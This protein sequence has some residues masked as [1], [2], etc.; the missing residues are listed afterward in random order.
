MQKA[1]TLRT[2]ESLKPQTKRYDVRD[3]HLPGFGV[4]VGT[5]GQITFMIAYRYG[6]KQRRVRLGRYP[7]LGLAE[8]RERAMEMLRKVDEGGDP[9]VSRRS[10]SHRVEHVVDEFITK[11]AKPKNRTWADTQALLRR[12]FVSRHGH[13]DIR[14]ITR[15]EIL[16]ILDANVERGAPY[17]ANR[18]RSQLMKLFNWCIERSYVDRNPVQ[19]IKPLTKERKRDRI[20]TNDEIKRLV[21]LCRKEGYP[22]GDLYLMLLVTGQRRGEATGMRWSEIDRDARVW[23]MPSER[24]KNDHPHSVPLSDMAL[25]ILDRVPRYIGSDF[26][27]TTTGRSAVSGWGKPKDRLTQEAEVS[28][29]R[30][31]DLRRTASSGM[32]SLGVA[33]H[34]IEKILNHVSG[35]ISGVAAVYNRYGYEMEK[36]DALDRWGAYLDDLCC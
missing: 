19:G 2:L 7:L 13:R 10:H 4:R 21:A 17:Q 22:F 14:T 23:R 6:T 30:L 8:A 12:E 28:G 5:G 20:L 32:A 29:W 15:A 16:D 35:T 24:T 18:A 33:P 1:L 34:V 36:R 26:V 25:A 31:H 3:S 27:F 9:S 11:Y